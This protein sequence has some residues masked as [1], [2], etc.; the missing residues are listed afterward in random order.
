MNAD[1]IWAAVLLTT[2][3]LAFALSVRLGIVLGRRLD[4]MLVARTGAQEPGP[5]DDN[6]V[7][8]GAR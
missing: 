4:R 7:D 2:A 5:G 6:G 8:G 3:A 1:V